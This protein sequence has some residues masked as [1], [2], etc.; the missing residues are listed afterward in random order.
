[1]QLVA[2][3]VFKEN[4]HISIKKRKVYPNSGIDEAFYTKKQVETSGDINGSN[5]FPEWKGGWPSHLTHN[6]VWQALLARDSGH[7]SGLE[8]QILDGKTQRIQWQSK[9]LVLSAHLQI[10]MFRWEAKPFNIEFSSFFYWQQALS[11]LSGITGLKLHL[12]GY[13]YVFCYLSFHLSHM[14]TI[15]LKLGK[16]RFV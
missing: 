6:R 7:E 2:S 3:K 16:E 12:P 5:F 1:M 11:S 9:L 8:D 15:S 4:F 13:F 14:C 10:R